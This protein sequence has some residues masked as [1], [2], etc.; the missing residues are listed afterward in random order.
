M[1][2]VMFL[3]LVLWSSFA[4]SQ[5]NNSIT[6]LISCGENNFATF[7]LNQAT[8][9]ALNG[10]N[11]V[12]F[13][14]GFYLSM[15]DLNANSNPIPNTN[16]FTNVSNPQTI[17]M[18]ITNATTSET[19][20]K[21]FDLEVVNTPPILSNSFQFCDYD[22]NGTETTLS[23][24][25]FYNY[26]FSP[27]NNYQVSY[28]L[29]LSDAE[30]SI[31]E[32]P[33]NQYY[34]INGYTDH[35]LYVRVQKA[36]TDCYSISTLIF[37]L[38]DCSQNGYPAN[39]NGCLPSEC[40]N[41][42]VNDSLIINSLNPINYQVTYYTSENNAIN[43]LNPIANTTSYCVSSNEFIFARLTNLQNSTYQVFFFELLLNDCNVVPSP[44]YFYQ[45]F[46]VEQGETICEDLSI[47]NGIV[48]GNL[49]PVLFSISYHLSQSDADT[50]LNPI[51]TSY[52]FDEGYH[53][54]Y[55][56]IENNANPAIY[57][58]STSTYDIT[59]AILNGNSAY[60]NVCDDNDD[61]I[62]HFNLLEA[63]QQLGYSNLTY[64]LTLTDAQNQINAIPNP[65]NFAFE[66]LSTDII[67]CRYNYPNNCDY[68]F[69]IYLDTIINCSNPFQ[70]NEA[71][72]LCGALG[73]PFF[74]NQNSYYDEPNTDYG[75]LA[76]HPNPTWFYMQA[77]QN[78]TINL[79]IEQNT[80]INFNSQLLDVD[81]IV[82]GP[83]SDPSTGCSNLTTGNI[84]NCSYS[85][86]STEFPI[87][88]NALAGQYYLIMVT[89]FSNQQ[90]Y[91]RITDMNP[92]QS[93]I[94][95]AGVKL[96][97]FIDSNNN[98]IKEANEIYFNLGKFEIEKNNSG[99]V[100]QIFSANGS[101]ILYDINGLNTYDFG[102]SIDSNYANYYTVNPANYNNVSINQ[103]GGVQNY[104]FPVV[105]TQNYTD[106]S[107][108]IIPVESP[109]PGFQYLNKIIYTNNSN[110]AIASGILNFNHDANIS[111]SNISQ[112]GTIATTNGF[113]YT[114][115]NLLPYETRTIWVTLQ[116]PT[117]V[118]SGEILVNNASIEPMVSDINS[119][120]NYF[121]MAQ[122]VINSYD[123]NDKNESHGGRI[124][125]STFTS[126]DYLYYTIRFENT[127]TASAV[128][129]SIT[130]E[131]NS[132]L[133][134]A[135]FQI[136][137][138]SH[139]YTVN[140]SNSILN[141]E[142]KNIQL[143]VSDGIST[144]G[145][146]YITFKIKPDAGYS[147]GDIIPN[148]AAIYFDFNPAIITNTF[149]TEFVQTLG[150]IDFALADLSYHPNPVQNLLTISNNHSIDSLEITSVL[151]QQILS[152]KVNSL[153]T[154]IDLSNFSKGIYFVKVTSNEAEKTV[155]IIKE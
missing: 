82:Y 108:T 64:Y 2:K 29:S 65:N 76:S 129:I 80:G 78:G 103:T 116:V 26:Y 118:M 17:F 6:N 31:N 66:A 154:E 49:D 45:S 5:A 44:G 155:K 56:R 148:T 117:T 10:Y 77:R 124:I 20:V 120:N 106:V 147:I 28:Y 138:S 12:D 27:N 30:N 149:T 136:V 92:N 33:Q 128:N 134:P 43:N 130:D 104:Y 142:F 101:Y 61:G 47:Y 135:T 72:S 133:N 21:N 60:L 15:G 100:N 70:C 11:P 88:Q 91:I 58:T 126:N 83:F 85:A 22:L 63:A 96:Q 4:M 131:L 111:I 48:I 52:C 105:S 40:F 16:N 122:E 102:F 141:F 57:Y 115:N 1:K 132:Q 97:A 24:L 67:Y 152:Q 86:Q 13:Q 39:L 113:S 19:F 112:L 93:V 73:T 81:Y 143:P 42:T 25:Y 109:R 146:G 41:L 151:G 37:S 75:C 89:N 84:I 139:D 90:G 114:Y 123:P 119:E 110:Q 23:E 107:V 71:N 8:S 150:I 50:D 145:K 144:V 62:V 14:V 32:I 55:S 38:S 79:K 53:L 99:Q 35:T 153:Q 87:I 3:L 121:S 137:S 68:I 46:C 98:A 127:G 51:S 18:L 59:I 9:Q 36:N 140:L 7:N 69:Y 34:T 94:E 74:N 125:H 95:C 54:I